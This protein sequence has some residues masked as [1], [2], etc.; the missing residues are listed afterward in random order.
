MAILIREASDDDLPRALE[1][2]RAAYADNPLSPILFPGPFPPDAQAQR[3]PDLIALR[4]T[5]PSVRFMQAYDDESGQMVAFAKWHIYESLEA[6]AAAKRPS[7]EFGAGTNR[8]ACE[9]FFGQLSS[10]KEELMGET[11]HLCKL[12]PTN[13]FLAYF[14]RR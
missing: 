12:I 2:E 4:K 7:R 1:I 8:E 3:V 14:T 10:R 9:D 11:P 13:S 5:D 6:A